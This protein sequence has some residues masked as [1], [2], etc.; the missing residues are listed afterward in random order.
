MA[1]SLSQTAQTPAITYI[2]LLLLQYPYSIQMAAS[3]KETSG[4]MSVAWACIMGCNASRNAPSKPVMVPNKSRPRKKVLT[5]TQREINKLKTCSV[6]RFSPKRLPI[7]AFTNTY[8]IG[9][10]LDNSGSSA[11]GWMSTPFS[12]SS[13]TEGAYT[14]NSSQNRGKCSAG[15]RHKVNP[16][17]IMDSPH[18]G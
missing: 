16:I 6:T 12:M 7:K 11:L 4:R 15:N 9:W 10:P 3:D 13:K 5:S 14:P 18:P 2:S 8:S 1:V 17:R